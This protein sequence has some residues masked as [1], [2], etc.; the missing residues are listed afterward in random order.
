MH[1]LPEPSQHGERVGEVGVRTIHADEIADLLG[2]LQGLAEAGH[3]LVAT[4]EVGEVAAEHGERPELCLA[5]ADAPRQL[6]RLLGD[7]Q[8]LRLPP[9]HHQRACE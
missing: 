9:A 5:G 8:R 3:T 1:R 6:E 2:E 4:A 7:R